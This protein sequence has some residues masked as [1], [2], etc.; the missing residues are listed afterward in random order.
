MLFA[1]GFW[2]V[3][4][5]G[6]TLTISGFILTLFSI[7]LSWWL[8]KRDIEKR[9]IDAQNKTVER[10]VRSLLQP[11]VQ[12]TLRCLKEARDSCRTKRWERAMDRC[13][14]ALHRIPS[15]HSLPGLDD[16]DRP[17]LVRATDQLRLLVNQLEE[18][19]A[20]SR[21][22]ITSTKIKDLDDLI[23]TLATIEGK[24]RASGLR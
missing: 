3:K 23:R 12:E 19:I 2:E 16:D 1:E 17:R 5:L 24:L 10:L 15:F 7:W 14:Q 8:A 4:S 9:I 6:D 13:E 21:P 20:K 18:V 11:E 22:E